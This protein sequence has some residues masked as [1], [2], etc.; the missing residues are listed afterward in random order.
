MAKY[1]QGLFTPKFPEKYRGDVHHIVFRSSWEQR[2]FVWCD[3]N[4]SV[5]EWSS[6]EIVIPYICET[7][8]KRHRYFLDAH[9][10]IKNKR[11]EVELYLV[12]IKPMAQTLPPKYPGKQTKRY[13]AEAE[14]FIKNQSKWKAA[15]SFAEKNNANFIILTEKE[16]GI[17][18]TK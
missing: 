8:G 16:L 5:I 9:V 4:A 17:G 13:L 15:K 12:E 14:T 10:K 1:K 7:D 3:L 2:F 6:E 11:G 18:S